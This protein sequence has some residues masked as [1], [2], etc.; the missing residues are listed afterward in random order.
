[1]RNGLRT[2]LV[3]M[4]ALIVV[5]IA[6]LRLENPVGSLSRVLALLALALAA[7]LPRR[8]A[9]RAFVA[10][11]AVVVAARVAVGVDLVPWR[12]ITCT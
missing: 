2:I 12:L 11:G 8:R 5:A 10:I 4:P 9:V 6:W 7:A 1:M 3:S